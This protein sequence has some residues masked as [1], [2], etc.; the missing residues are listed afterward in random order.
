MS[1]SISGH[2]YCYL[3]HKVAL[4]IIL[5]NAN[6]I[7]SIAPDTANTKDARSHHYTLSTT[8][9]R[10]HRVCTVYVYIYTQT[11]YSILK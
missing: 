11:S 4:R 8:V 6:E 7:F 2:E 10:L 9:I 3:L 1:S 5:D